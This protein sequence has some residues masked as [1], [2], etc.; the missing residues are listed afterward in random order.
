MSEQRISVQDA[1]ISDL[2]QQGVMEVLFR[3][4]PLFLSRHEVD[5]LLNCQQQWWWAIFY[6]IGL[7]DVRDTCIRTG[8]QGKNLQITLKEYDELSLAIQ[9]AYLRLDW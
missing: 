1:N 9:E 2:H 5:T 8:F 4:I 3:G 6:R 7:L